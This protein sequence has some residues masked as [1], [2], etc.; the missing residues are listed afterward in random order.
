MLSNE[1][2]KSA[3]YMKRRKYCSNS[4]QNGKIKLAVPFLI[5]FYDTAIVHF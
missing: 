5:K 1:N 3:S 2:Y 4:A